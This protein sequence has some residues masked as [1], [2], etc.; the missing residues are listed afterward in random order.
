[1]IALGVVV[2]VVV[3]WVIGR[4]R[5]GREERRRRL[6]IAQLPDALEILVCGLRAGLPLPSAMRLVAE[7]GPPQPAAAFA[8]VL[9]EIADGDTVD[10]A[11]LVLHDRLGTASAPLIS[12]LTDAHRLG[13]PIEVLVDRLALDARLARRRASERSARE[14]PVRLTLPLVTCVLPS[15]VSI[16]IVPAVIGTF[17]DLDLRL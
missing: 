10:H 15:F 12:T 8:D 4:R 3:L 11:L 17:S 9:R 2:L 6:V 13:V 16:V 7:H 5:A 1:M 14:L